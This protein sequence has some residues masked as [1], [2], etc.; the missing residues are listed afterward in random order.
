MKTKNKYKI[1][2]YNHFVNLNGQMY[3]Y[4]F[5]RKSLIKINNNNIFK[6]LDIIL[7][8]E[9][10]KIEFLKYI[11]KREKTFMDFY[12]SGFIIETEFDEFSFIR[13]KYTNYIYDPTK[14][15]LTIAPTFKCN[16]NC[17]YCYQTKTNLEMSNSTISQLIKWIKDISVYNKLLHIEWFG[18]EPLLRKDIILSITHELKQFCKNRNIFYCSS[19]TTNG[20][21]LSKEFISTTNDLSINTIHITIDGNEN[22]HNDYRKTINN[23]PTFK[24]IYCNILNYL[25]LKHECQSLVLRINCSDDNYDS[26]FVLLEYFPISIRKNIEIYFRWI[27]SSATNRHHIFTKSING[28]NS[29]DKIAEL[30]KYASEKGWTIKNP[31]CDTKWCYCEAN[32]YNFYMI[33]P[34]GKIFLCDQMGEVGNI[35]EKGEVSAKYLSAITKWYL[36]DIFDNSNCKKCKILPLCL[37]GCRKN[38]L[39]NKSSCIIEKNSLDQFV[40]TQINSFN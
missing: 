11:S 23:E 38:S 20:Y 8:K 15:K 31:I 14:I 28:K 3:G 34:E 18:G 2:R 4:N 24:K 27:Y 7:N 33:N 26:I 16:F 6:N 17:P 12:N 13:K 21:L 36:Y 19:L 22:Y 39:E 37:G 9:F 25:K 40:I 10:S 30:Y 32:I 29:Y 35:F 5:L 1:S